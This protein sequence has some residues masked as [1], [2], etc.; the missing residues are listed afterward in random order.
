VRPIYVSI[1]HRIGL[2]AAER[3]VLACAR[4]LRV[5]VPTRLADALSRSAKQRMIDATLSIVIEQ[6]AGEPGRWEWVAADDAVVFRHDLPPMPT[7]YGCSVD[8]MN[9]ADGEWLDVMLL[10]E[11]PY[12]RNEKLDVRVVD[13]LERRDGDHKLLALPLD[14]PPFAAHTLRRTA[15]ARQ[16]AW[17]WYAARRKPITR[18]GGEDAALALI[19][20]CRARIQ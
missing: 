2:E 11:R 4:G 17:A 6:R 16:H 20:E 9:D 13:V 5:P 3:W 15:R 18:W 1:G 7:H 14:A 12:E 10:D 8:L 19:A